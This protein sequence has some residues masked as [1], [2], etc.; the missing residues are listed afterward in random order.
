MR[1]RPRSARLELAERG[2]GKWPGQGAR[3]RGARRRGRGSSRSG[4]PASDPAGLREEPA[5]RAGGQTAGRHAGRP[6]ER[7]ELAGGPAANPA[8]TNSP[9][10]ERRQLGQVL[11]TFPDR[12]TETRAFRRGLHHPVPGEAGGR[13]WRS[14]DMHLAGANEASVCTGAH[15]IAPNTH[16]QHSHTHTP[17]TQ[18]PEHTLHRQ[19]HTCGKYTTTS[20]IHTTQHPPTTQVHIHTRYSRPTL[21]TPSIPRKVYTGG[22]TVF[23]F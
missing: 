6:G 17:I 18:Q 14:G 21:W 10:P 5:S 12:S 15:N 1:W 9:R 13:T 11:Q 2:R 16:A 23:T 19:A 3:R 7:G 20:H 4:V 22:V 8:A